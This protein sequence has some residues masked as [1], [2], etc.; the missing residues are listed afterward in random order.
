[1]KYALMVLGLVFLATTAEARYVTLPGGVTNSLEV[2]EGEAIRI[3]GIAIHS[4]A[5]VDKPCGS[6]VQIPVE[7]QDGEISYTIPYSVR[8]EDINKMIFAGPFTL[9]T[10]ELYCSND[11]TWTPSV[12]PPPMVTIEYL[13]ASFALDKTIIVP[14]GQGAN[15]TTEKSFD[16][17]SWEPATTGLYGALDG[18]NVF[19]RLKADRIDLTP[20]AP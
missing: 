19:F 12:F 20:V 2:A 6:G 11:N 13:P 8:F 5:Y 7:V 18:P 15:V 14:E 1:M 4:D 10:A 16:L 9:V 3:V 17:I